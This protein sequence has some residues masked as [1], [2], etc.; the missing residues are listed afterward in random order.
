M[1]VCACVCVCVHLCVSAFRLFLDGCPAKT[2]TRVPQEKSVP[3][4]RYKPLH[5]TLFDP[6]VFAVE[7]GSRYKRPR[8]ALHIV[9]GTLFGGTSFEAPDVIARI[10]FLWSVFSDATGVRHCRAHFAFVVCAYDG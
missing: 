4:D 7:R 9:T 10:L 6:V 2:V 5:G 8:K 3:E 1:R